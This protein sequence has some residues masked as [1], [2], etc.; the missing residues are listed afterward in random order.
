MRS[1]S[2]SDH[3]VTAK[4]RQQKLLGEGQISVSSPKEM[5]GIPNN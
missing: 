3:E 4:G 5:A 1:G 2:G